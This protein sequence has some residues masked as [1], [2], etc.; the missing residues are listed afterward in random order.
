MC[1]YFFSQEFPVGVVEFDTD[2]KARLKLGDGKK[3]RMK[4]ISISRCLSYDDVCERFESCDSGQFCKETDGHSV[5][6]CFK[7]EEKKDFAVYPYCSIP[8]S[9]IIFK[10]TR[11][12]K[13]KH[14]SY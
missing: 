8:V 12:K 14:V 1:V 3:C 10:I 4:M 2:K 11:A 7:N 6:F 5:M 13:K 9:A